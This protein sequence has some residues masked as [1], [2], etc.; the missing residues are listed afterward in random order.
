[1]QETERIKNTEEEKYDE[2]GEDRDVG[3]DS[4]QKGRK[5]RRRQW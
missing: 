1:M 3:K 2:A 4:A 5:N